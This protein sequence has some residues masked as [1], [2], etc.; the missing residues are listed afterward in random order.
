MPEQVG[1]KK[2]FNWYKVATVV[3][4]IAMVGIMFVSG[5]YYRG[6]EER[7]RKTDKIEEKIDKLREQRERIRKIPTVEILLQTLEES[8]L[9]RSAFKDLPQIP[10]VISIRHAGGD[11]AKGVTVVVESLCDITSYL[12]EPCIEEFAFQISE[13]KKRLTMDVPQLRKDSVVQGTIMCDCIGKMS[14]TARVD[15]G[16][17][18]DIGST[19]EKESIEGY[20]YADLDRM[21]PRSFSSESTVD[22][23]IEKLRFLIKKERGLAP[24]RSTDGAAVALEVMM[25]V[26]VVVMCLLVVGL[27]LRG[28]RARKQGNKIG[29]CKEQG[30]IKVGMS[31]LQVEK[32]LGVPHSISIVAGKDSDVEIWKY[33]PPA[34]P[35]FGWQPDAFVTMESS[36]VVK[37]EY[38]E[39]G[40]RSYS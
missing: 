19:E 28:V 39:Y 11:T 33:E 36:K 23:A 1:E 5:I 25:R 2:G 16:K 40:K 32:V 15:E 12:P 9:P 37:L 35:F 6:I 4:T 30:L 20:T 10:A 34:S 13:D 7:N 24:S 8:G 26:M 31:A 14:F 38:K 29:S 18:V 21:N 3:L 22:D 17:V 27:L